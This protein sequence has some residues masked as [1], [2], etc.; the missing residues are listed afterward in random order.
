MTLPEFLL[1]RVAEDEAAIGG[2]IEGETVLRLYCDDPIHWTDAR[3]RAECEAKRQ[4]VQAYEM[5]LNPRSLSD[6]IAFPPAREGLWAAIEALAYPY[7][8][9]PDY[10]QE[11]AV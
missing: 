2:V 3:M 5:L 1:A 10:Q 7:A 8:N 4:I 6:R 11:W 9:H